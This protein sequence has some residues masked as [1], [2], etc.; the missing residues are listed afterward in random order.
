MEQVLEVNNL[1]KRFQKVSVLS[2]L[3]LTLSPGQIYGLVG[4]NGSGKSTFF[5]ILAGLHS[6]NSGTVRI[7]GDDMVSNRQKAKCHVG[8]VPDDFGMYDRLMVQESLEFYAEAKGL[9]GLM[10]RKRIGNVLEQVSLL[11]SENMEVTALSYSM[12]RRF[13]IAQALLGEP[14]LLVLDEPVAGLDLP[15]RQ[16]LYQLFRHLAEGGTTILLSSHMVN[17]LQSVCTDVGLL[18]QGR[19]VH[20]IHTKD[21]GEEELET[22]VVY[23]RIMGEGKQGIAALRP[24]PCVQ[25]ISQQ[26]NE[27]LVTLIGGDEQERQMLASLV[28]HGV[29]VVAFE[30]QQEDFERMLMHYQG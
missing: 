24:L 12:R 9:S 13:C 14:E 3:S 22:N 27:L 29:P 28:E 8:F 18:Q 15:R 21:I 23:I 26:G 1:Y 7:C 17:E 30:R 16:S 4:E 6:V 10:A 20:E 25:S 5:R 11:G 19:I 2:D